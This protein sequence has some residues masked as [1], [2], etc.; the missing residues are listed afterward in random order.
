MPRID[1]TEALQ[2]MARH[3]A[4]CC[5]NG[6]RPITAGE[7]GLDVVLTLEASDMSLAHGG[8]PVAIQ[9]GALSLL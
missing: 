1:T 5:R 2:K 9:D 3:F 8:R 7:D 4:D 6:K